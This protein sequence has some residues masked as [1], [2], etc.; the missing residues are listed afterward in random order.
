[1]RRI[2][3]VMPFAAP[4]RKLNTEPELYES[5][6]RALV[7]RAYSV[8]AMRTYL[9]R[10]TDDEDI[11]KSVVARLR[12]SKYLDDARYALDFARQRTGS[13]RQGRFRIA[14]ELRGRGVADEHIDAALTTVFQ[15]ADENALIR[16]RLK[17]ALA[18]LPKDRGPLEQ[19]QFARLYR[20]LLRA[21]F[22]SDAVRTELK[23]VTHGELPD[24]D[25]PADSETE[26]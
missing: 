13:R 23:S 3:S 8:H 5:A 2:T 12:A 6:V 20:S 16:A 10:R 18:H 11:L 9:A 17:R 14:R 4:T 1:M 21:G 19:R 25:L 15:D 22:S 7:R 24:I 26:D